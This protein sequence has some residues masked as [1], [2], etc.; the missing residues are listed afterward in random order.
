MNYNFWHGKKVF[1]TGH[2]GFKGSWIALWLNHLGAKVT[3]FALP[4]PTQPNLFELG[5]I[6]QHVTSIIGDV[7]DAS[8]LQETLQEAEPE[9]VIHMAA[10]PLVRY[11]YTHPV[12]TYSTNI[13]GLVN[14]L[15]AARTTGSVKSILNVTSDKCYEN[16]EQGNSFH[17]NDPIGGSDPYSSSKGCAELITASYQRSYNLPI[18][19]ARSGNVIGGGDWA[20]DRL[21]P[22]LLHSLAQ[23]KP[24]ILRN[25]NA[26]RPWQHVLEPLSGYLKLCEALYEDEKKYIGGWNFG[27]DDNDAKTVEWI[28]QFITKKWGPNARYEV[29]AKDNN[30]YESHYLTLNCAK[31]KSLLKWK[32]LWDLPTSL[33]NTVNWYKL[34]LTK[35]DMHSVTMDQISTYMEKISCRT[36]EKNK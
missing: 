35:Q 22:D 4:A 19:S 28:A 21:L 3:G 9:I 26:I 14:L 23:D 15:E 13:M 36:T 30:L 33:E 27:P 25:P 24:A 12:E 18:A 11:S 10:Q 17:E 20:K 7:R 34:Y 8:F 6:E 31:A 16:I 5:H 32:P 29:V 2:T 1:L